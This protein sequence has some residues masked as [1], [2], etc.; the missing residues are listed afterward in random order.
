[1]SKSAFFFFAEIVSFFLRKGHFFL[2]FFSSNPLG[3]LYSSWMVSLRQA[4][5]FQCKNE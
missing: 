4:I 5:K 2:L 1:M 3:G